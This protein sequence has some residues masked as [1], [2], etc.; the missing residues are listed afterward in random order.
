MANSKTT[1]RELTR[2]YKNVLK[3]WKPFAK[4]GVSYDFHSESAD[5]VVGLS[6]GTAYYVPNRRLKRFG[7]TAGVGTEVSAGNWDF[8][9][10]YDVDVRKEYRGHTG[11]L[12]IKYHF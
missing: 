9:I 2:E 10:G 4:V 12:K 11:S 3:K 1:L 5:S 6:N 8:S 7:V